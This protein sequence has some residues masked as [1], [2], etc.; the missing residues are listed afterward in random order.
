MNVGPRDAHAAVAALVGVAALDAASLAWSPW[1]GARVLHGV[2]PHDSAQEGIAPRG[3]ALLMTPC[4][5]APLCPSI[6]P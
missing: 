6:V 4:S 2:A 3:R 5:S 1:R